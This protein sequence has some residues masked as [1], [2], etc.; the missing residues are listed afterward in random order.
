MVRGGFVNLLKAYLSVNPP[1]GSFYTEMLEAI[2][3]NGYPEALS[4][5]REHNPNV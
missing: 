3:D 1:I 4:V 5:L 2:G